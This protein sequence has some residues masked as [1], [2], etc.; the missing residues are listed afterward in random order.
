MNI[1]KMK[2][3]DLTANLPIIQGGMG[4]GVSKSGLAAAVAKE[5]AIGIISGAQIGYNEADFE[6]NPL[7]ANIRALKNEIITAKKN[8]SGGII[9][10]NLMVAMKN[11]KELVK[12][13]TEEKVDIIISGAGLPIDLPSFVQNSKVKLIPIVSS[14]KAARIIISIWEKKH[15]KTPDAIIVEGP[16]AGGHLGFKMDKLISRES[17]DLDTIVKEVINYIKSLNK[18]IPVIAA[19]GIYDGYDIAKFL[20]YGAS[21]VQMATRF[22]PTIECDADDEFKHAYIN[23]KKDDIII[24]K[25]PVGLPGRAIYNSFI[26]KV[27]ELKRE[28]IKKCYMCLEKCDPNNTPYCITKALINSVKGNINNGLIFVG[29]NAYKCNKIETVKDVI[30]NLML[31]LSMA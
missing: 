24:T 20:K 30:S 21:G 5:G 14:M 1:P 7:K 11:Y 15:N 13:A 26:H 8:S 9:G 22:V 16:E 2:I 3:G 19:G 10:V 28:K 27:E 25:S 18:K 6:T 12:V 4:I 31:E 29:S 23:A 17:K